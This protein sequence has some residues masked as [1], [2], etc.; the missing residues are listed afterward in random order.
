MLS[1]PKPPGWASYHVNVSGLG[2]MVQQPQQGREL[3]SCLGT[4]SPVSSKAPAKPS[5]CQHCILVAK[6]HPKAMASGNSALG[7]SA[8]LGVQK[9]G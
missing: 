4:L 6:Q 1:F 7:G 3:S 2:F 8:A 5:S 9:P